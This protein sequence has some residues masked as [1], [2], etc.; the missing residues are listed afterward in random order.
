MTLLLYLAAFVLLWLEVPA[1][2]QAKASYTLGL[3]PAYAVLCVAGLD[4]LPSN[5]VVRAAV[6]AFVLCWSVLVYGAYF[7]V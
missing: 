5:R 1:F 6:F 3:T 7:V 4:L 2:S